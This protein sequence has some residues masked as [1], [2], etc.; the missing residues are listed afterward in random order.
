[1]RRFVPFPA[2]S[3]RREP[4]LG[5]LRDL[6]PAALRD[7]DNDLATL[8]RLCRWDE[9]YARL[10]GEP[11][12]GKTALMAWFALHPPPDIEVLC[13]FVTGRVPGLSDSIA[14]T[15]SIADQLI[16]LVGEHPP[17][18]MSARSGDL[19]LWRRSQLEHASDSDQI[20]LA[21]R[22]I[23]AAAEALLGPGLFSRYRNQVAHLEPVDEVPEN[24]GGSD[25]ANCLSTLFATIHPPG[26]RPHS[27]AEVA[28]ALT[29]AGRPISK[30][31]LAQ[32]RS[33]QRGDP[34]E[35]TIAALAK[36][37]KVKPEYFS[38]A[39]YRSQ[40]DHDLELL[41]QLQGYGLR[42]LSSRAF[43]LSGES[44]NLLERLADQLR[45][46]EGLP[47]FADEPGDDIGENPEKP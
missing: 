13:F 32:L 30:A 23:A 27:N 36:F 3:R 16:S 44:Q 35:E 21:H 6:V 10:L 7:R 18:R 41:S 5:H 42:R 45:S 20:I 34:S 39:D 12:S 17:A 9:P 25:F 24:D 1:M 14:F 37:F 2:D 28:A 31:Y 15:E 38:D 8:A 33:G 19:E 47:E 40:I 4:H 29:A 43:D 22:E 11:W 46:A 26:R